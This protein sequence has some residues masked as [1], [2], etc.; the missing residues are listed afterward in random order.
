ME[1]LNLNGE[2]VVLAE[3]QIEWFSFENSIEGYY[4]RNE[5][6]ESRCKK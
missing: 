1:N 2:I 5:I 3:Y 6:Q 4:E